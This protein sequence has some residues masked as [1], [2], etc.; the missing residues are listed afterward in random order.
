MEK[1]VVLVRY[2]NEPGAATYRA[3]ITA[4][5]SYQA[6]E[7]ARAMYGNL[8]LSESAMAVSAPKPPDNW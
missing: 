3:H 8:L 2:N 5:N 7:Q 1:F 6:I 4:E